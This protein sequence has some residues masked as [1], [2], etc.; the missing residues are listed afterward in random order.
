MID[1]RRMEVY[2]CLFNSGGEK[3]DDITA[4]II[5]ER[6]FQDR[7][8]KGP[9]VFFG[10]GAEKCKGKIKDENAVFV[11]GILP[12]ARFI[13][14]LAEQLWQQKQFEDVA[15]FEP[16]YLKDFIA[17]VPKDKIFPG[18]RPVN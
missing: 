8:E 16:F 6:S 2:T 3:L 10:N 13:I 4:Q 11:D 15:Y 5:D 9:V 18:K 12:S 1:A 14:P 7:L 17:T